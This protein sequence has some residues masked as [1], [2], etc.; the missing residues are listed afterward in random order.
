MSFWQWFFLFLIY[1]PLLMLWAVAVVDIFMRPD[2]SG[3]AKA[4]WVAGLFIFP[5]VGV[6][7]YLVAR[8]PTVSGILTMKVAQESTSTVAQDLDHLAKLRS[9]GVLNEAEFAAAKSKVIAE[10]QPGTKAA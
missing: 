5:W 4:L 10:S 3:G 7:V 8:P 6:V 2:L 9:Q 1:I